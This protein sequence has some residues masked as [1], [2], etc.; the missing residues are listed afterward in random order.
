[1]KKLT[2]TLLV[3]V[4]AILPSCQILT[5]VTDTEVRSLP[6]ENTAIY[7]KPVYTDLTVENSRRTWKKDYTKD[8]FLSFGNNIDAVKARL[9]WLAT[10]NMNEAADPVYD[11][12]VG[13]IYSYTINEHG[14]LHIELTGYPAMFKEFKTI[15]E[16]EANM[17]EKG[18]MSK[19][20]RGSVYYRT[21]EYLRNGNVNAP[22]QQSQPSFWGF[23][24]KK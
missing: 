19:D 13:A 23:G 15:G 10:K 11:A 16:T 20:T 24:G 3:A 22:V 1:M 5:T 14:D 12:I 18:I 9:C 4:T 8:E 6:T 2:T 21:E 7:V 17:I